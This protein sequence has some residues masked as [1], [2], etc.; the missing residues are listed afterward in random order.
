MK[1]RAWLLVSFVTF[2]LFVL[3]IFGITAYQIA[4]DNALKKETGLLQQIVTDQAGRMADPNGM[5][6]WKEWTR[7]ISQAQP[8]SR[9]KPPTRG[10]GNYRR[11]R[12]LMPQRPQAPS[13]ARLG[14][15]EPIRGLVICCA[16]R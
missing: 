8:N 3:L 13:R 11:T 7:K 5:A 6:H 16:T 14:C 10:M 4:V 12:P 1:L 2:A 15:G 9:F